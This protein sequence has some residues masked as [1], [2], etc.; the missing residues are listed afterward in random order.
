[1]DEQSSYDSGGT[2]MCSSKLSENK[3][4]HAGESTRVFDYPAK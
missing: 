3:G 2:E 4:E 1:M